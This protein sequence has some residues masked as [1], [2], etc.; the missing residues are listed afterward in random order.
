MSSTAERTISG[1]VAMP[2]S[3]QP[4]FSRHAAPSTRAAAARFELPLFGRAVARQ[5]GARQIAQPDRAALR[6]VPRDRS[7]K[8]DLDIVGM[9]TK[10]E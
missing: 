9:R 3:G 5:L 7:A 10:D 6:R 2:P 8:A 4:R 1:V